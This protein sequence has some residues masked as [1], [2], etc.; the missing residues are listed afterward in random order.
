[1]VNQETILGGRE[2]GGFTGYPT[3]NSPYELA[4]AEVTAGFDVILH[5]TNHA[6]DRSARGIENCLNYW[7]SAHPKTMVV[8]I[9]DNAEDQ[10]I[11][12]IVTVN[13]MKIA[14]LNY[15]YGT[16]GIQM[17]K[18]KGYLVDYLSEQRVRD[19]IAR[20]EA[21]ADFTIVCPHWGTEYRLTVSADQKKWMKI[22]LENGVDLVIGTHPHVIEPVAWETDDRGYKMLVYYSLGN[23]VNSTATWREGVMQRMV[24]GMAEVSIS[25]DTAGHV[26]ISDYTVRPVVNHIIDSPQEKLVTAYFLADYT[27]ELADESRVKK[28]DPTFSLDACYRLVEQVWPGVYD[29]RRR[30][31]HE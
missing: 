2:L 24:G 11:I 26:R 12:R 31:E 4:D 29:K 15:T 19:D 23:F 13:G 5:G 16:N 25:R 21:A 30:T 3:F 14:I 20:A 8:G 1:I 22:F 27:Q 6:L 9:H 17:P 28:Q 10:Q 7:K 18:G